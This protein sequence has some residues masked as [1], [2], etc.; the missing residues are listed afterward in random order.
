MTLLAFDVLREIPGT[1]TSREMTREAEWS[2]VGLIC[3]Q[4]ILWNI[5]FTLKRDDSW[6]FW[7]FRRNTRI[8]NIMGNDP[9][10]HMIVGL[11]F[12]QAILWNVW[13]TPYRNDSSGFWCFN[14]NTRKNNVLRNDPRSYVIVGLRCVQFT[15]N[16][17]GG[18]WCFKRYIRNNNL[19][20]NNPRSY[21]LVGCTETFLWFFSTRF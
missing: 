3:V 8:N 21:I 12:L 14:R 16:R 1:R 20:G 19:V 10:S 9:R 6:S 7:C 2:W 17:I 4:A 13:F 18:F 11:R 5:W 15:L